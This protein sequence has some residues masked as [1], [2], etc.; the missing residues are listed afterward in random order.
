MLRLLQIN[1]AIMA[2]LGSLMLGLGERNFWLPV[3][4]FVVAA[5]SVYVTDIRRWFVLNTP[6]ANV[7]GMIAVVVS[8]WD[9]MNLTRDAKLL[10]LAD[11]LVYLQC[12][13]LYRQKNQRVYWMLALLSLLQ[14][15]V[16]SVLNLTVVFPVILLIYM[17]VGLTT[18]AMF[19]MVV[20]QSSHWRITPPK[21]PR[22]AEGWIFGTPVFT[23]GPATHSDGSRPRGVYRLVFGMMAI[24]LLLTPGVFMIIPR[25]KGDGADW[26]PSS[27]VGDRL[28]GFTEQVSLGELGQ[29][30]E[31]EEDVLRVRFVNLRTETPYKC[32]GE[33]LLRGSM[34][35]HYHNRIW[36]KSLPFP[37]N[38]APMPPASHDRLL[39]DPV[40]DIVL[41]QFTIRPLLDTQVLF[42]IH[43]CESLDKNSAVHREINTND[44]FRPSSLCSASLRYDLVTT[45]LQDGVQKRRTPDTGRYTGSMV[46]ATLQLPLS[47]P[48]EPDPLAG[49]KATAAEVLASL[50]P[51]EYEPIPRRRRQLAW[52]RD[53]WE[54]QAEES[55]QRRIARARAL[56]R[57]L[58]SD[59]FSYTLRPPAR[60]PAVDP[61]EDFVMTN[62]SGHCEY[63][64]SALTLMLRSQGIPARMIVGFKGAEW[65]QYGSFYQVRQKHA[66]SW[67]EAYIESVEA[68]EPGTWYTL[69]PTPMASDDESGMSWSYV[70]QM[71]DYVESLWSGY[72]L[73]MNTTMQDEMFYAPISDAASDLADET[74]WN[75]WY[76][77]IRDTV[78]GRQPLRTWFNWRVGVVAI[79]VQICLIG[80]AWGL[81]KRWWRR[82]SGKSQGGE[83]D[84]AVAQVAFYRRL[85]EV[86]ARLQLIRTNTQTPREFASRASQ[87]IAGQAAIAP[88]AALP[89]E[90]VDLYY[91][92]RF[93]QHALD[94][95]DMQQVEQSLQQ[96][97][98]GIGHLSGDAAKRG[99][100]QP[101]PVPIPSTEPTPP[102]WHNGD[103]HRSRNGD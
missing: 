37:R 51:I 69:D 89:Q 38:E 101:A 81:R 57:Y 74:E 93:G 91:R 18:L 49:L 94:N 98:D 67:V 50:P 54:A 7:A 63:F 30:S 87:Q 14:V 1:V 59:L 25:A 9:F 55:A 21:R 12:V 72:V 45:G 84:L 103:E 32:I 73:G 78:T 10:A 40:G 8:T 20:E 16:A 102:H 83:G 77:N 36:T 42:A 76:R 60:D 70:R 29:I 95:Q 61:I 41:Q 22:V 44:I 3:L 35:T 82:R 85:E 96:L 71:F 27:L 11:L 65:N 100:R 48:G 17:F 62:R 79:L 46:R 90:L 23:T 4:A 75:Y 15:A 33:P 92:V 43:P 56:E 24:T 86:L 80:L 13:L 26:S 34:L 53:A 68:D 97:E 64:A 47:G 58:S 88:V 99:P 31:N 52:D 2:F 6:A 28:V 39:S 19:L 66:H 5:S